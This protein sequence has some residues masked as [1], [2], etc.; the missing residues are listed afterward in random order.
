MEKRC[1]KIVFRNHLMI[2]KIDLLI[3]IEI[4]CVKKKIKVRSVV[5]KFK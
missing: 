3:E 2:V 5:A 4:I 1:L